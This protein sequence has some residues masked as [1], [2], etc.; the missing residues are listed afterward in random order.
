MK[1]NKLTEKQA[2]R[3]SILSFIAAFVSFFSAMFIK[4]EN[5]MTLL[6]LLSLLLC[7]LTIVFFIVFVIKKII[8]KIARKKQRLSQNNQQINSLVAKN[9]IENINQNLNT[10]NENSYINQLESVDNSSNQIPEVDEI[11]NKDNAQIPNNSLANPVKE[12]S[13]D[14]L[15]HWCEIAPEYRAFRDLEGKYDLKYHYEDVFIVGTKHHTIP[16]KLTAGA[17]L[18]IEIESDNEFDSNAVLISAYIDDSKYN[19]GYISKNSNLH[20]MA[21]DYIK[22]KGIVLAELSDVEK[23]TMN[24]AFFK[25]IKDVIANNVKPVT[26]FTVTSKADYICCLSIG[27][28][29]STDYDFEK[30]KYLIDYDEEL[31]YVP[32]SK[33]EYVDSGYRFIVTDIRDTGSFKTKIEISIFE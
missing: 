2:L 10:N 20:D 5:I 27:D 33:E 22:E 3:T 25:E 9:N 14:I 24:I 11:L 4:N 6:A 16:E 19:L 18:Y 30:D 17:E 28:E 8:N 29:V 1:K 15:N 23:M 31:G 13:F 7:L 12:S 21:N 26:K 32:K